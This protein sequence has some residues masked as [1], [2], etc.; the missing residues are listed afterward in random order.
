MSNI[1]E[2]YE[3]GVCNLDLTSRARRIRV[4]RIAGI[5][6]AIVL[7]A[8]YML[9]VPTVIRYV[10]TFALA[11][12]SCLSALEA[13]RSFCVVNAAQHTHEVGL[14]KVPITE[15][16]TRR[17]DMITAINITVQAVLSAAMIALLALWS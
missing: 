2:H 13:K 6:T 7:I 16:S 5:A 1:N 4:A 17:A 14:H 8:M 11:F 3:P 12:T 9:H 10:V 15:P